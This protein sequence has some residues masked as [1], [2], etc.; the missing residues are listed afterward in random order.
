MMR[1]SYKNTFLSLETNAISSSHS[2]AKSAD[3]RSPTPK[4]ETGL[5]L[6]LENLNR[7]L[8]LPKVVAKQE[9]VTVWQSQTEDF[10]DVVPEMI[11]SK[12]FSKAHK[13]L[14]MMSLSTMASDDEA[15]SP[16]RHVGSSDSVSTMWS[17][18]EDDTENETKQQT[19]PPGVWNQQASILTTPK[20][21]RHGNVPKTVNLAEEYAKAGSTGCTTT[22]MIR[23][24]PNRYSQRDLINE[25]KSL[26]FGG[27]FDFLYVPLDLG[28]MSNVGYAFVNFTHHSWAEKCMEVLQNHRFKRHR[29]AGKVAAVSVAHIQGLE[30]NLKH[31]EKSAVNTSRLRQRR[32]VV[33]AN[34]S[35]LI[36]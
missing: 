7:V 33:I 30:A 8:A 2:R 28:T 16:M 5:E 31:Y 35:D 27:S 12:P 20:E 10:D 22:L 1:V 14:S 21:S 6:H 32:P 24:V 25:L 9:S 23:N 4:H 19:M 18:M 17:E 36:E 11:C 29:Q 15:H 3:S 13:N 26:G 34:M